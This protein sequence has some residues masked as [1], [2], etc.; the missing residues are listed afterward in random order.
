VAGKQSISGFFLAI[1]ALGF[2]AGCASPTGSP[3]AVEIVNSAKYSDDLKTCSGYALAYHPKF[4]AGAIA[5][6]GTNG[7]ASNAASAAVNVIIP[8]LGA[9]GAAGGE[10]LN[11]IDLM[12]SA[13]RRVFLKCMEKKTDRDGSAL[14]LDPN[15]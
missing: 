11:Q 7:A 12:N 10:L 8:A 9:L 6:A 13:Q 2:L 15:L 1:A 5:E 3:Y 14:V 4:D